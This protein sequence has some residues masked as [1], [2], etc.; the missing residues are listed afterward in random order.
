M[1]RGSLAFQAAA[2][3][4]LFCDV[5][6]EHQELEEQHTSH[7]SPHCVR[8]AVA[9]LRQLNSGPEVAQRGRQYQHRC[10]ARSALD[11]YTRPLPFSTHR[12]LTRSD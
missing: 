6:T 5:A 4:V 8:P 10:M 11:S 1:L 3:H 9:Q 7:H 2:V 12:R